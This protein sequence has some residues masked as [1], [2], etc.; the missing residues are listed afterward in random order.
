MDHFLLPTDK[1]SIIYAI[2][3]AKP[4]QREAD[5]S[6]QAP[7]LE[8]LQASTQTSVQEPAPDVTL[9]NLL[10][11]LTNDS[12][13]GHDRVIIIDCMAAVHSMKKKCRHVDNRQL[14]GGIS[15]ENKKNVEP[16]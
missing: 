1:A 7:V 3:A 6:P 15:K 2:E 8:P 12:V 5:T 4:I 13:E 10:N 16:V 9:D 14:Q 11:I